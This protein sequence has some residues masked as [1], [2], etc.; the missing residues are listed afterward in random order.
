MV[1]NYLSYSIVLV[2]YMLFVILLS[3]FCALLLLLADSKTVDNMKHLLASVES[4]LT[5]GG[6]QF[7]RRMLGNTCLCRY[8]SF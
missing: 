5:R 1:Y 4:V 3:Y 8:E 7:V 2:L 6:H